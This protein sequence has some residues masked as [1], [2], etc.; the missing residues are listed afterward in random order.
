MVCFISRVQ[1]Y[2]ITGITTRKALNQWKVNLIKLS[3]YQDCGLLDA[4]NMYKTP[5]A[6]LTEATISN[7]NGQEWWLSSMSP[8]P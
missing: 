4:S 6:M 5:P 7:T 1:D 8:V 3:N 2:I